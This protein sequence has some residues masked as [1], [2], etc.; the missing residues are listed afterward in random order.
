MSYRIRVKIE[1][2]EC[3]DTQSEDISNPEAGIYEQVISQEVGES[4]DECE[5]KLLVMNYEA[6]R[7]SLSAHLSQA[8]QKVAEQLRAEGEE[9][10]SKQ[11]RVD[12]ESGAD[13]I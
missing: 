7:A 11:Y 3:S 13:R 8:S 4:I 12:G 1:M 5:Q 10:I 2:S 9:V 6:I